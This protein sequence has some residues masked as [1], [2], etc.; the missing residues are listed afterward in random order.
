MTGI[1][2]IIII[3]R[4]LVT[5]NVFYSSSVWIVQDSPKT[6]QAKCHKRWQSVGARSGLRDERARHQQTDYLFPFG[7]PT[8]VLTDSIRRP[9]ENQRHQECHL[10]QIVDIAIIVC[11]TIFTIMTLI[12]IINMIAVF[13]FITMLLNV[14][15]FLCKKLAMPKIHENTYTDTSQPNAQGALRKA[16]TKHYHCYIHKCIS[17]SRTRSR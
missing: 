16:V 7:T 14:C 5:C 10:E 2:V 1:I 17:A 3:L 11:T 15:T 12:V 6:S 13:F 4:I 9:R 8:R